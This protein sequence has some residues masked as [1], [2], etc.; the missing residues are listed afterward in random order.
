MNDYFCYDDTWKMV[1]LR[2]VHE[3]DAVLM[4]L[5]G[6]SRS[7]AGCVFEIQELARLVPL[8]RV[9]FIVDGR[10]DEKL[11]A[12]TLGDCSAGVVRF[13]P[14]AGKAGKKESGLK[15]LLCA[16]AAAAAPPSSVAA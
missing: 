11:L 9:V 15:D 3:S 13:G 7:N 10:T 6:F 14:R 5:R 1:L 16:L 8:V 4:D 2:L 12:E